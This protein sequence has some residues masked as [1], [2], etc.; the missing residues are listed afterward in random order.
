MEAL[1]SIVRSPCRVLGSVIVYLE[2]YRVS[3]GVTG[4]QNRV[5]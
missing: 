1:L 4:S 5:L 2:R 3:S